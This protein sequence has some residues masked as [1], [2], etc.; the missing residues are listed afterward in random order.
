[1]LTD[2]C[3]YLR[4]ILSIFGKTH[5]TDATVINL[6]ATSSEDPLKCVFLKIICFLKKIT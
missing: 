3:I 6:T 1:M 5:K 4:Y 2:K